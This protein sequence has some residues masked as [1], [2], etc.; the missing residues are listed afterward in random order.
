MASLFSKIIDREIPA[1]IVYEDDLVI[2]I[3]DIDPVNDGHT[4]V[5]PKEEYP[6]FASIPE[7]ALGPYFERVQRVARAVVAGVD[8]EGF[9]LVFNNGP[10]SGQEVMHVHAHIIPRF[11]GDG[12]EHWQGDGYT[13][14]EEKTRCAE[15]IRSKFDV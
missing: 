15:R 7:E 3:L 1:D 12:Y 11:E 2:A 5:I 8:A 9:N 6:D 10:A 14:E 4:L 13:S